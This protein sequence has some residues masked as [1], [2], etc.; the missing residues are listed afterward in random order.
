MGPTGSFPGYPLKSLNG[1]GQCVSKQDIKPK[2][3]LVTNEKPPPAPHPHGN[4]GR[5]MH[6]RGPE[7][8]PE[9][10]GLCLVGGGDLSLAVPAVP[11]ALR[12]PE[13][14]LLGTWNMDIRGKK[15]V[16]RIRTAYNAPSE[17]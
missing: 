5:T 11:G 16:P 10:Q 15:R 17:K 2:C 12:D 4:A 1:E 8:W 9:P 13:A 3:R 7:L 6:F 14:L